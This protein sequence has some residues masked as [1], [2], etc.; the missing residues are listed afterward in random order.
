MA[1][2]KITLGGV[3]VCC[4]LY[5]IFHKTTKTPL[6]AIGGMWQWETDTSK[7]MLNFKSNYNFEMT[8]IDFAKKDTQFFNGSWDLNGKSINS[9]T[10][11]PVDAVLTASAKDNKTILNH[12]V[13]EIDKHKLLI[14]K[15]GTT[16]IILL[17]R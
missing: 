2:K 8:S 11:N 13:M 3:L 14:E 1:I 12:F 6:Q 15:V 17:K 7:L 9:E 16:D 4:G 10:N 5:A